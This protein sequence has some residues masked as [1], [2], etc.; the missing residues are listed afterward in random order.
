MIFIGQESIMR[1]LSV[2]LPKL[3]KDESLS[4]TFLLKAPSG[5]GKTKMAFSICNYLSHGKF[6]YCLGDKINI[7]FSERVIFIDEVHLL[8]RPEIIYPIIDS[9]K[10][11]IVLATNEVSILPEALVNRCVNLIFA[12]YSQEEL[13]EMGK[14]YLSVPF[15]EELLDYL[16][17]S[18]ARNPRVLKSLCYRLNMM[19]PSKISNLSLEDFQMFL[20]KMFG[21][22]DGMDEITRRYLE[23]LVRIGGRASLNTL[24]TLLHVDENTI[25]FYVEPVLIYKGLVQINSRGRSIVSK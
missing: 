7:A 14:V 15:K 8:E 2:Y 5:W 10:H 3:R 12:E 16:I 18:S 24:S 13:R 17:E 23:T 19:N 25:R 21:I 9:G 22:K 4:M 1:Q 11:V 6:E 20:F